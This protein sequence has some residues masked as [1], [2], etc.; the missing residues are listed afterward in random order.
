MQFYF[1][2]Q[3]GGTR[4]TLSL[5][6]LYSRPDEVLFRESHSTVWSMAELG[7]EGLRVV[8]VNTILSVVSVQPH[9]HHVSPGD[10]RFFVWEQMGLEMALLSGALDSIDNE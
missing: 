10:T 1:N 2:A 9:N 4:Q 7:D 3:I 6:R 8:P 5:I